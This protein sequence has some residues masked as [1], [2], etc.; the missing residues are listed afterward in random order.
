MT[1]PAAA[2]ATRPIVYT[3]SDIETVTKYQIVLNAIVAQTLADLLDFWPLLNPFDVDATAGKWI[4]PVLDLVMGQREKSRAGA[5]DFYDRWRSQRLGD[6]D[7]APRPILA[8]NEGREV[9]RKQLVSAGPANLKAK[10]RAAKGQKPD[11]QEETIRRAARYTLVDFL[12]SATRAV[13]DADREATFAMQD[14]DEL[15]YGF[16]RVVGGSKKP[17]AFCVMLASRGPVY[18]SRE[19]AE[20]VVNPSGKRAV[21]DK[22][23][24]NCQCRAVPAFS[25]DEPWFGDN[26]DYRDQYDRVTRGFDSAES[27]LRFRRYWEGRDVDNGVSPEEKRKLDRQARSQSDDARA[28]ETGGSGQGSSGEE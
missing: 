24:D 2:L 8:D 25:S 14:L 11:T 7:P 18:N 12:G 16:Q 13:M 23:H 28:Q 27:R 6:V 17:C 9:V 5:I 15:A 10:T 1:A 26:A 20:R 19:S 4:D 21:G 22:Y 3:E